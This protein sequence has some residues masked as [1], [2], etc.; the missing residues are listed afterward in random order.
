MWRLIVIL[1]V[2]IGSVLIGI[3]AMGHPGFLVI[4]YE[5]WTIEVPLWFAFVV[6]LLGFFLFYIVLDFIDWLQ[7]SGYRLKNW[8]RYRKEH[9]LYTKTH[10]GLIALIEGRYSQ[11]E[12][13][14]IA[15][16][17]Q[18]QEPLINFLSAAKAAHK[19]RA[20]DR[21]DAYI[22]KAYNVAPHARI[23]VGLIRAELQVEQDQLE[24]AVVTL[25]NLRELAPRH[26]E[27]LRLL[28]KVYV[29]LG[30]WKSLLNLLPSLQKAKILTAEQVDQFE[31]NIY[32]ERLQQTKEQSEIEALWNNIPKKN[33]K[34]PEVVLAY[35]LQLQR[36]PNTTQTIED[37][38]RKILK[39]KWHGGL[40][41]V[42]GTLAFPDIRRQLVIGAAWQKMYGV[43]AELL[44]TLG[45][46]CI[47]AQLWGKARDYFE[48]SLALAPDPETFLEYGRLLERLAENDD[49]KEAYKKGV[50][51]CL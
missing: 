38:I 42:Y 50:M 29:R 49:A 4:V 11:A 45:R 1:L 35:V 43:H 48:R 8:F 30:D 18:S 17:E 36:F 40:V 16:A 21:R 23:A 51:S 25:D 32:C 9:K 34:N 41:R 28:E 15:G 14:L 7:F 6:L 20:Y 5:P 13:L 31:K 10:N 24:Q 44:L 37:L 47:K 26:P 19:Q 46:L 39:T 2:L 27:V 3:A 12:T 33:K 22:Q